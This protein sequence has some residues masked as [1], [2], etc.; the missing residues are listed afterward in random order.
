M[1]ATGVHRGIDQVED[2][3]DQ[4]NG[5]EDAEGDPRLDHPPDQQIHPADEQR[6]RRNLTRGAADVVEERLQRDQFVGLEGTQDGDLTQQRGAGESIDVADESGRSRPVRHL[7][8]EGDQQEHAGCDRRIEDVLSQA[9]EGHLDDADGEEGTD[10]DDPPGCG[11]RQVHRQ[12]Q[13]RHERRRAAEQVGIL[14]KEFGDRP[15]EQ[16]AGQ[17]ADRKDQQLAPAVEEDGYH[18]RRQQ[19]D[20]DVPHQGV[21]RYR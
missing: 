3:R 4:R 21:S 20:D 9:A 8:R 11:G 16:Y 7:L 17:G 10:Y 19:C 6:Q 14:E 18:D 2:A 1:P 12:Q 5:G 13:T 15:L